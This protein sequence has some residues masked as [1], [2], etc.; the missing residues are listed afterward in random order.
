ML[1]EETPAFSPVSRLPS[2][3]ESNPRAFVS[4]PVRACGLELTRLALIE[5]LVCVVLSIIDTL[6]IA[7]ATASLVATTIQSC[8]IFRPQKSSRISQ[9]ASQNDERRFNV[10]PEL[11]SSAPKSL[12]ESAT[13]KSQ[14]THI[15]HGICSKRLELDFCGQSSYEHSWHGW[16]AMHLQTAH[17]ILHYYTFPQL[18]PSYGRPAPGT[19]RRRGPRSGA[20]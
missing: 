9:N 15:A 13:P 2:H 20:T 14:S 16:R 3:D 10:T 8:M 7:R 19:F 6:A 17:A 18:R 1:S 5:C 11:P 4:S 12:N